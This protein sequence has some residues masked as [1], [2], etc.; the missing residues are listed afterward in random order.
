MMSTKVAVGEQL[1]SQLLYERQKKLR[2]SHYF[3]AAPT[4]VAA[5]LQVP[6]NVGSVFRLADAV[7]SQRVIL[8]QDENQEPYPLKRIHRTA[9][10]TEGL[11][12]WEIW[13]QAQ[14][15]EFSNSLRPLIAIE[16]TSASTSIFEND[17]PEK[18]AFVIG[19][20]R[21]GIPQVLLAL[22]QQAVHIP[23]Y[24]INGSMNVTHA[25]AI[26]LYEWRRQH[27]E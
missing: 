24:G 26:A 14:F 20:E 11:V 3:L 15:L 23:M 6:E 21:H 19:S 18:C 27:M 12:E 8:V 7:G 10:S 4:I 9:R 17:L 13:T 16:L 5:G 2:V 25:L 1:D 22:C